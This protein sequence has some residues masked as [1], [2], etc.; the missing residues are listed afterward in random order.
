MGNIGGETPM[1][2]LLV[3][4]L[5]PRIGHRNPSRHLVGM[6]ADL[7][8]GVDEQARLPYP[9]ILTI[10]ENQKGQIFLYRYT[11]Q[12]TPVGDTWHRTVEDATRQA[13]VEYS[14]ELGPWIEVPRGQDAL[15]F[16][17]GHGSDDSATSD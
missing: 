13:Q 3:N 6:P 2:G 16:A 8:G 12:G 15:E 4:K 10:E 17:I 14:H 11:S 7:N 1:K 5:L 9:T